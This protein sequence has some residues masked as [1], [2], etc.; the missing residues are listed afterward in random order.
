MNKDPK[1]T[2]LLN[3]IKI[4]KLLIVCHLSSQLLDANMT[5][6]KKWKINKKSGFVDV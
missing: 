1:I 2:N 4:F 5:C 3:V 6:F